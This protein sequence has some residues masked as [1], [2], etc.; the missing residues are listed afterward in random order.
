M[1][2]PKD[3]KTISFHDLAESVKKATK[4][5]YKLTRKN[6]DEDVPWKGPPL[7]KCMQATCLSFEESL[8]AKGLAFNKNDQGRDA[9]DVIIGIAIQL[10]IEQGRRMVKEEVLKEVD[11]LD[12]YLIG[13]NAE[14]RKIQDRIK[15]L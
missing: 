5:C 6:R 1:D 8:S 2:W 10:G 7:P 12:L 14:F 11:Y 13:L 9:M 15:D 3:N 4:F